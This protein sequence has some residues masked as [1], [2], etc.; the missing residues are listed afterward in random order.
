MCRHRRGG[1]HLRIHSSW[2][3]GSRGLSSAF[4]TCVSSVQHPRTPPRCCDRWAR[5]SQQTN[6]NVES[7]RKVESLKTTAHKSIRSK[8]IGNAT[9]HYPRYTVHSRFLFSENTSVP[10]CLRLRI[11][12][13]ASPVD[14]AAPL[15]LVLFPSRDLFIMSWLSSSQARCS[16]S[17]LSTSSSCSSSSTSFRS[18]S[19]KSSGKTSS[20]WEETKQRYR[21]GERKCIPFLNTPRIKSAKDANPT[22]SWA[23]LRCNHLSHSESFTPRYTLQY[24]P[25]QIHPQPP[26]SDKIFLT[27]LTC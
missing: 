17:S 16:P 7:S 26:I 4:L 6:Q 13:W 1:V 8:S 20:I 22:S 10:S 11:C 3:W 5:D 12:S 15:L 2:Q 25:H 24:Q 9:D 19:P 21:I 18:G 27:P 23:E 14:A